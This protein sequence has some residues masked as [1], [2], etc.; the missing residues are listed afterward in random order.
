MGKDARRARAAC[1]RAGHRIQNGMQDLPLWHV[2]WLWCRALL[3]I[4]M[5][6]ASA[7]PLITALTLLIGRRGKARLCAFGALRLAR[8]GYALAWLGPPAMIGG[9]L[10]LLFTLRGVNTVLLPVSPLAPIMLPFTLTLLVWLAGLFCAW[11]LKRACAAAPLPPPRPDP[12]EDRYPA[13]LI[14]GRLRLSLL[15]AL[16]FFAT[17]LTQSW[18]FAGLPT[19]LSA[20]AVFSAIFSHALHTY[21][22]AFAPAGALALFSLAVARPTLPHGLSDRDAQRAARW[23]A[24]WAMI[25]YIPF[26]LDRWGLIIGFALRGSGLPDWLWPQLPPLALLTAAV[27][28]WSALFAMSRPLRH[29]ALIFLSLFL[30]LARESYP[31]IQKLAFSG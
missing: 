25:G 28:C 20:Q 14:K 5:G 19:G 18:P 30:L 12:E 2:L 31:Y 3:G 24:L 26:C 15:A 6:A 4:G 29:G 23:C 13:A 1:G 17:Y 21:F 27:A 16:C 11:L 9:Y 22:M 7:L 8:L 10:T